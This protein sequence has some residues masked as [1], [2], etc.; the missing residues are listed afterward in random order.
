MT[1]DGRRV[2]YVCA[3]PGIPVFGCKGASVHVQ[4]VIRALRRAGAEV[5]LYAARRGGEAPPDLVDLPL[6]L[7]PAPRPAPAPGPASAPP[8]TA[9]TD[10]ATARAR[11]ALRGRGVRAAPAQHG[12]YSHSQMP[13]FK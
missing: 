8:P 5:H 9:R 6:S 1:G 7:V 11:R 2:A 10:D 3:D 13:K 4:E 12:P